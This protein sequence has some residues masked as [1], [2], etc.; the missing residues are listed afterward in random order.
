MLKCRKVF[1][2]IPVPIYQTD[3]MSEG[4][5]G[6]ACLVF[7]KLRPK[8]WEDE[9]LIEHELTHITW[10]YK[11]LILPYYLMYKYWTYFRLRAEIAG[12]KK[13]LSCGTDINILALR[14]ANLYNLNITTEQAKKYIEE[15]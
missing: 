14:L 5:G 4:Y 15:D 8:Y 12:Y 13:Q 7:I 6:Q 3:D 10:A 1:G 11:F 2:F 9:P